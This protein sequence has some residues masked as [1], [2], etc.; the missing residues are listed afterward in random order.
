MGKKEIAAMLARSSGITRA[1]AADQLDRVVFELL[2]KLRKGEN[3][4]LPG[5]GTLA[6]KTGKP[7]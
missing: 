3:A 6:K 2:K 1:E 4:S 7:Q 5:L